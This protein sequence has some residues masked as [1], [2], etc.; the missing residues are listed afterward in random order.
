MKKKRKKLGRKLL[1]FLLTLALVL[2]LMPGMGLT[3]YAA[4]PALT[5]S[6]TNWTGD[7]EANNTVTINDNVTVTG[8]TY[9]YCTHDVTVNGSLTVNGRLN[10]YGPGKLY[11]NGKVVINSGNAIRVNAGD[12]TQ[13]GVLVVKVSSGDCITGSGTLL[14]NGH[15]T[16]SAGED[17]VGIKGVSL[18]CI[19]TLY[20]SDA[21]A[22]NEENKKDSPYQKLGLNNSV[23]YE[24]HRYMYV[25]DGLVDAQTLSVGDTFSTD[26]Y[27]IKNC[28]SLTLQAGG[29]ATESGMSSEPTPGTDA[30]NVEVSSNNRVRFSRG[31]IMDRAGEF[32]PY[33]NGKVVDLWKVVSNEQGALVLTGYEI[34]HTHNFTYS[35]N[36][37]TITATCT[38]DGCD[39]P[40]ST[41]GGTDHVTKLSLV[42]PTLTIYGGTGDA[43]ATL[44]G[45][46]DFN[47]ATGL[48][49]QAS[50]IIYWNAKIQ[51]GV[52]KTDG[53]QPLTAAPTSAGNYLAKITV[54]NCIAAVGYTINKADPTAP[55][56][57][58][59]TYGQTL[60]DVTLPD[61]WTWKDSTQS[62]G[63]VVSPAATFK[64]NFAEN[65]NY[66]AASDVDVNVTVSKASN[67][68]T[69]TSSAS[70]T[71]GNKTVDLANNVTLNGATGDVTYAIN[72]ETNGCSLNGS[73]LTSGVNTGI[74]TVNVSVAADNNYNALATT[75]ITVTINKANAVAA[76]VTA[77]NRTYDGMNKPLVN[78]TGEA[79][80]GEM[81]YAL[82]TKEAATEEYTT[83]IPARTDAGTYYVWYIV[84]GDEDHND[85]Q[86]VCVETS[87]AKAPGAQAVPAHMYF[88]E[89]SDDYTSFNLAISCHSDEYHLNLVEGQEYV[90]VNKGAEPDWS[91][92]QELDEQHGAIL[93]TGL[94][95]AT[96]YDIWSRTKETANTLPG[97]PALFRYTTGI[98]GLELT[99]EALVGNTL[100]VIT[101]PERIEGLTWQ[102]FYADEDEDGIIV[103]GE[104]ITNATSSSYTVKEADLGKYLWYEMYKGGNRLESGNIGPVK[105]G[106]NPTVTL[107]GWAYGDT[108]NTPVVTGN[109]GNGEVSFEYVLKGSED[110]STET[111]PTLPGTYTVFAYI[112]GSGDYAYGF[113]QADF[114][115]TKGTPAV[116]EPVA[117]DLTYT[118]SAQ[119]LVASGTAKG[120]TIYYVLG[121]NAENAPTTGWATTIPTAADIGTY[122]VWYKV[123]GD[124]NYNDLDA[125]CI[126]VVIA[127]KVTNVVIEETKDNEGKVVE[128]AV[129][130]VECENLSDFTEEQEETIV[131][132]ELS[133]KPVSEDK[134]EADIAEKIE[135][136]ISIAFSDVDEKN[137][138]TEYLELEV[139]K[140][141]TTD[142]N[143]VDT[144]IHDVERVLEIALSY[145]LTGKYNPV[146]I[147]E[148]EGTA[149]V[150]TKLSTRP[151][152]EPYTDGTFYVDT[153]NN[154][155]YIYSR[156]FSTYSVAYSTTPSWQVTFDDRNGKVSQNVVS[157]GAKVTKPADPAK[158]G[159]TFAGWYKEAECTNAWN[160]DT[161]TV[162]SDTVI[163]AKWDEISSV[164]YVPYTPSTP[165]T[166]VYT[167]TFKSN[168]GTGTMSSKASSGMITLPANTFERDGFIFTGWN[169]K[170]DGT[171]VDY[172]DKA[173]ISLSGDIILYA[174]WK[175]EE[176]VV[177]PTPE[178]EITPVVVDTITKEE[179]AEGRIDINSE[180]K[181][182]QSGKKVV[183]EW[184][185]VEDADM[186]KVYASYCSGKYT[187]IKTV[188]DGKLTMSFK[189]LNGSKINFSKN[190]KVYVAAYRT[191][192]GEEKLITKTIKAHVVGSE[193]KKRTNATSISTEKS[194]YS[195]KVGKKFQIKAATTLA[196]PEKKQLSNNHAAEF[197]YLSTDKSIATVS[198]DGIVTGISKGTC[199]IWVYSRNGLG[200]KVKV[201]VK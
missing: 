166:V 75:P 11:V 112:E 168:G 201:T 115:I 21:A 78:V 95:A 62:V 128:T 110:P 164:P 31:K 68:A 120:G 153:A 192:D 108:P 30:K 8:Y 171:G 167:I 10:V 143:T 3:A 27:G 93:Y 47:T 121:E 84:K 178:P 72:G 69:V 19:G 101:D 45:V 39:L 67:P 25:D 183:V 144:E 179:K 61:G 109:T 5:N 157:D 33:A 159:Y 55:T 34:S 28:T 182:C 194:K 17:G 97:V 50:S 88:E 16:A 52:Y 186:Y 169:L 175:A 104:A 38:A 18:G 134:V 100:T 147:R 200:V 152:A 106:I 113:A 26:L 111:V 154:K 82:G 184:G 7:L 140:K 198:K 57:L 150:F 197:R 46:A 48:N 103:R 22:I 149:T 20:G 43:T 131:E 145:D 177:T 173:S 161:D 127:N 155:I 23:D 156:Y 83:D 58:T 90:L 85:L 196:D 190:F 32:S 63:D 191:I 139:T 137:I 37:A 89:P 158:D 53:D 96:E 148:H 92:A 193:N 117:R 135:N 12:G 24:S 102:W 136:V 116:S 51:E 160:F 81:Q 124:A 60:A 176:P 138:T 105:I 86:A 107:E 187:L 29:Y 130:D 41:E 146:I 13:D 4:R 123:V 119:A 59:A 74:V 170:A 189:K 133:V 80:G 1:S 77:N 49:V 114:V 118:E 44:D 66:N 180:F 40:P 99:E 132:V 64:A 151:A 125:V 142:G 35:V 70:I 195:V 65:D 76:T 6:S 199:Y 71:K 36:G 141:V 126:T 79:K 185:K 15:V 54:N 2:G 87:I 122:Y 73:V 14:V 174:Q 165:V 163:Y 94:G 91:K 56:G 181:V 162:T 98:F 42:A 188:T 129:T 172:K 9:L